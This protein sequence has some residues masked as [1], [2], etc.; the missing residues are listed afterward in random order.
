VV[1]HCGADLVEVF[2][3]RVRATGIDG[4]DDT[5]RIVS[6]I[7]QLLEQFPGDLEPSF[8]EEMCQFFQDAFVLVNKAR[9]VVLHC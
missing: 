6:T 2:V 3:E 1:A 4:S 7:Q 9:C 5:F 8:Q